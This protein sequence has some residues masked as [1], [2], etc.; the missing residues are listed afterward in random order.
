MAAAVSP[1][2]TPASAPAAALT[3]VRRLEL[4]DDL[5]AGELD[6]F[7]DLPAELDVREPD[8]LRA[9]AA[10]VRA[11]ADSCIE[12]TIDGPGFGSLH[13]EHV[14]KRPE[15]VCLVCV[16]P[17]A[18]QVKRKRARSAKDPTT[19]A[20]PSPSAG[21]LAGPKCWHCHAP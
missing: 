16:L 15:R 3:L 2:E 4:P 17:Q 7:E 1:D 21:A 9:G 12:A 13:A 14:T 20:E 5:V 8:E 10:W 6:A 18:W 19:R 11:A